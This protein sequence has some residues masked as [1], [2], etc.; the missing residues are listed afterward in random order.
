MWQGLFWPGCKC[1][2]CKAV[3][4]ATHFA[5]W[6]SLN[7]QTSLPKSPAA[8]DWPLQ[9]NLQPLQLDNT[10]T[11]THQPTHTT[12]HTPQTSNPPTPPPPQT[13]LNPKPPKPPKPH[14][15]HTQTTQTT[16]KPKPTNHTLTVLGGG[17]FGQSV[18]WKPPQTTLTQ[19]CGCGSNCLESKA[20]LFHCEM[21]KSAAPANLT[22]LQH[23]TVKQ[24]QHF[25]LANLP[26]LH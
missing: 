25:E 14:P 12:T 10:Q 1:V 22:M 15:N 24:I 20:D 11:T 6:P 3:K 21:F 9:A 4:T 17:K 23:C 7:L 8:L 16:P 5:S 2:N 19:T 13:T 18:Q 26:M